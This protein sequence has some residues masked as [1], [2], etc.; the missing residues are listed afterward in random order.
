M[1]RV[2]SESWSLPSIDHSRT[3]PEGLKRGSWHVEDALLPV[4]E[5]FTLF[6]PADVRDLLAEHPLAWVVSRRSGEASLLPLLGEYD[7]DGRLIRL[8]GHMGRRNPL[9]A[10]LT[11]NPRV[12]ILVNGPHAYV[13]PE[14]AELR[15]WGPTWNYA[16]LT[17]VADVLFEPEQADHALAELTKAMEGDRWTSA[18]LG[19]RYTGMSG[20]IVAFRAHVAELKGRFKLG[21]DERREVFAT[22][23][24]NHPDASLVRWMKRFAR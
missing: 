14:H 1:D 22:I 21:Q 8:L 19:S 15:D 11:A 9:F 18:E 10:D 6:E 24:R 17:V 4:T 7:D 13:S 3:C 5:A 20:A 23:V 2:Q 16:Q 12:T